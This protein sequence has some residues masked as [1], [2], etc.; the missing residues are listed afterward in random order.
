M[1]LDQLVYNSNYML[2]DVANKLLFINFVCHAV[3]TP[4]DD[5]A[6]D[7]AASARSLAAAA[8]FDHGT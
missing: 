3:P 6:A 2:P 1:S 4:V 5:K 7:P 8:A